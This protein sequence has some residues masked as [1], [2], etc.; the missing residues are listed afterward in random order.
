MSTRTFLRPD[1]PQ[2]DYW[3]LGGTW[4]LATVGG[5]LDHQGRAGNFAVLVAVWLAAMLKLIAAILSL[6]AL[7][8]LANPARIRQVRRWGCDRLERIYG[9]CQKPDTTSASPMWPALV[10]PA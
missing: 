8:G 1:K 3:G 7:H 2:P 9:I 10:D 6:L 4:L 5:S